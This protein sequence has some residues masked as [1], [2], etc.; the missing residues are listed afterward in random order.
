M[1][2]LFYLIIFS[3]LSLYSQVIDLDKYEE[4]LEANENLDFDGLKELYPSEQ[5]LDSNVTDYQNAQYY[6]RYIEKISPTDYELGLLAKNGF[7]VTERRSYPHYISAY[8]DIWHNDLPVFITVESIMHAWHYSLN[9]IMAD[10]EQEYVFPRLESALNGIYDEILTI[11]TNN[12]DDIYRNALKSSEF[13]VGFGKSILMQIGGFKEFN[14]RYEDNNNNWEKLKFI[15]D[16]LRNRSHFSGSQPIDISLFSKTERTID[17]SQFTPN[18]R[19]R[20]NDTLLKYYGAMMWLGRIELRFDDPEESLDD[21]K[22]QLIGSAIIAEAARKSGTIHLFDEIDELITKLAGPQDNITINQI[23]EALEILNFSSSD[24]LIDDNIDEFIIELEKFQSYNPLYSSNIVKIENDSA[25]PEKPIKSM[26]L[27]GQRPILDGFT[28]A[29]V[30]Y[31]E[32]VHQGTK[33]RRMNPQTND[34]M[35]ALGNNPSSGFLESELKGFNY[36]KNLGA[37]RY[38]IDNIEERY[39]DDNLYASWL[40]VIREMSAKPKSYRDEL[41]GF[42]QTSAY[43]QK[44]LTTQHASWAELRHDFYLFVKNPYTSIPI[45]Y[46]PDFYVEPHP[47][48][49]YKLSKTADFFREIIN[50]IDWVNEDRQS[51]IDNY[52]S[53]LNYVL[54]TLESISIKEL[55]NEEISKAEQC[56]G[57]E[58]FDYD[59]G[60]RYMV[61]VFDPNFRKY[62]GWYPKLYFDTIIDESYLMEEMN[63]MIVTSYHTTPA[64]EHEEIVGW[65]HHAG[66]GP[67]NLATVVTN[68]FEGRNTVFCGPVSSFYT[69]RSNDFERKINIQWSAQFLHPLQNRTLD[70]YEMF[71]SLPEYSKYYL[72]NREGEA[73]ESYSKYDSEGIIYSSVNQE[74]YGIEVFPNPFSDLAS[75]VVDSPNDVMGFKLSI[76]DTQGNMVYS[77]NSGQI[78]RGKSILSWDGKDLSG[79]ALSSGMYFLEL[80]IDGEKIQKSII[81]E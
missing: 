72:A 64:N 36:S 40:N 22:S 68:N 33:V 80:E 79:N 25:P 43:W 27:M 45:C 37:A 11:D 20:N 12:I 35:F 47:K 49:Y 55:N 62:S 24:L 76:Y 59:G 56:F 31:D 57:L 65:V 63:E 50:K 5:F 67:I 30:T 23:N 44:M 42:M 26:K 17:I 8:Y 77:K 4:F 15:Y 75:I 71:C 46:Y 61:C 14:F 10:L 73:Y 1:K 18:G 74:N 38:L 54:S 3:S 2:T 51:K 29:T 13:Y 48:V 70:T 78:L 16:M 28:T 32:I 81:K 53:D 39:W 19:Y 60:S 66:T 7:A 41:P 34:I 69:F 21:R 9:K 58:F 52:F 6:D